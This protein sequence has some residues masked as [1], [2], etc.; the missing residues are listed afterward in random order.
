MIVYILLGIIA[1]FL[2]LFLY[3]CCV[4]ATQADAEMNM[5]YDDEKKTKE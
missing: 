3:S 1:L 4:V 5:R 2:V